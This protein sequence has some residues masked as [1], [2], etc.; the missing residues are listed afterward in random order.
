MVNFKEWEGF[1]GSIWKEEVNTRDFI[2]KNYVP[3]DDG[4]DEF[5]SSLVYKHQKR[6]H[7]EFY[8]TR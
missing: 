6:Q 7:Y 2:Q 5:F 4:C 8:D 1:E 3:Y